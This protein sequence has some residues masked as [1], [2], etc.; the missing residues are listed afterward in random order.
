MYAIASSPVLSLRNSLH[1]TTCRYCGV[2]CGV[3]AGARHQV[4]R[5]TILNAIT[6]HGLTSVTAIGSALEACTNCG[7]CVPEL[8][9]ILAHIP[10]QNAA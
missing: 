9:Q 6:Q 5:T 8:R 7:S 10:A 4:Q 1:S 3:K 2:G